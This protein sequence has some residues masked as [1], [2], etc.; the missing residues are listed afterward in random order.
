VNLIPLLHTVLN[1]I[2]IHAS[3]PEERWWMFLKEVHCAV[4]FFLFS[5]FLDNFFI[6]ISNAIMKVPYSLLL[7]C[8]STH[9]LS[10][11][12]PAIPLYWGI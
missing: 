6:Y 8:S 4:L 10:L 11:P 2:S 1:E 3:S 12:G 5:F 7:P 9:P